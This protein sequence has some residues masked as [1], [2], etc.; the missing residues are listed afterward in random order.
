MT[1]TIPTGVMLYGAVEARGAV[2]VGNAETFT[3]TLEVYRFPAT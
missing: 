2:T 1:I 3:V